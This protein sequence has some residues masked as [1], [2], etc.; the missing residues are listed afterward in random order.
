MSALRCDESDPNMATAEVIKSK[1]VFIVV[2]PVRSRRSGS[3]DGQ[4]LDFGYS[5]AT[6]SKYTVTRRSFSAAFIFGDCVL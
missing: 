4:G 6:R 3:F 2:G 5:P 1:I